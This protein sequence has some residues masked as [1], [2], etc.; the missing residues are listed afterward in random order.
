M[1]LKTTPVREDKEDEL[2]DRIGLT[3]SGGGYRAAAF[4]L[5]SMSYLHHLRQPVDDRPLLERVKFLSTI[6]GGTITGAVYAAALVDHG[7]AAFPAA[8]ATLH[9]FLREDRLLATSLE[10]LRHPNS[11]PEWAAG[12]V[13]NLINAF[14]LEYRELTGHRTFKELRELLE[15][16][17]PS[18][19][20]LWEVAFGATDLR[21]ALPFRFQNK[22]HLGNHYLRVPRRSENHLYLG[23]IIAA[24]SAFPG[25]FEAIRFPDDFLAAPEAVGDLDKLRKSAAF[26]EPV[27][28]LDGGIVSNQGFDALEQFLN[29]SKKTENEGDN[30]ESLTLLITSDV[31]GY[32]HPRSST[33]PDPRESEDGLSL[34]AS[35]LLLVGVVALVFI[36]GLSRPIEWLLLLLPGMPVA[37]LPAPLTVILS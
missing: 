23:D 24:S 2:F 14:A 20:H 37:W 8:Y 12:K 16:D 28:L 25:G 31:A 1:Y 10:R 11:W 15:A 32:Y 22:G 21:N 35:V 30:G 4:H 9:R 18:A 17:G 33:Q 36:L 13:P 6:S 5:G 34:R 7:N 27:D 19:P 3:L 26:R 29:R